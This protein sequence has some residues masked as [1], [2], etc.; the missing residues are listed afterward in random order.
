MSKVSFTTKDGKKVSFTVKSKSKRGGKTTK[1]SKRKASK[2]RKTHKANKQHKRSTRSVA[3][4]RKKSKGGSRKSSKSFIDKIPILNNKTV[5]K[6][7]FGLGMG[8]VAK[9]LIDLIAQFGP[10]AIAQPLKQNQ[11]LITLGVEAATEPISAIVDIALSS[12]MVQKFG[13]GM[14]NN[15]NGMSTNQNMVGFA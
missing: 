6:V 12:G 5:Q 9:Q 10:P 15:G 11:R 1:S 3:K 4:G 8:V 14:S 13:N 2:P 7:G